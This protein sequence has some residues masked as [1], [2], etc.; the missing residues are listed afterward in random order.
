MKAILNQLNNPEDN[1][2]AFKKEESFI[3]GVFFLL[4]LEVFILLIIYPWSFFL[5]WYYKDM[6]IFL[7]GTE[8]FKISS[9]TKN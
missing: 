2:N 1:F 6:L 9:T 3:L 5:G 8:P 7:P 4:I